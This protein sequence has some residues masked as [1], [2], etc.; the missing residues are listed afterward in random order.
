MQITS[1]RLTSRSFLTSF[2][3][4]Q[5]NEI[6]LKSGK[7]P[8]RRPREPP[9]MVSGSCLSLQNRCVHLTFFP[10]HFLC[11]SIRPKL[12]RIWGPGSVGPRGSVNRQRKG[13][14]GP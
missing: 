9:K 13:Q 4:V 7:G 2:R 10:D 8:S 3:E 1:L 12:D 11:G 14:E 5:L 6:G